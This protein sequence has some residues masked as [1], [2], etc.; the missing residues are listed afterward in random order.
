MPDMILTYRTAAR[1]LQPQY[2]PLDYRG[3]LARR[4]VENGIEPVELP[5]GEEVGGDIS[6]YVSAGRWIVECPNCGEGYLVDDQDLLFQCSACGTD[7]QWKRVIMPA[8]R[9]EIDRLLL[10]RPGWQGQAPHR[11]WAPGET[12]DDLRRENIE[13]GVGV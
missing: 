11:N 2:R 5:Q 1:I 4:R 13:H 8:D 3:F 7:G 9:D 12:V 6:G 10:L